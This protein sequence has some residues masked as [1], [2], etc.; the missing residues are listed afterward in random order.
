MIGLSELRQDSSLSLPEA[1][2]MIGKYCGKKPSA[3]TCSRWVIKGVRGVR[4]E[5]VR[6]GGKF[7]TTA[8][9]VHD[10]VN[11]LSNVRP[12]MTSQERQ[13][14][15]QKVHLTSPLNAKR[16]LDRVVG[17]KGGQEK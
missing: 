5:A 17:L 12:A 11:Q 13:P 8:V 9:A 14:E 10:F 6:I 7:Y 15:L 16:H 3:S 4:L 1:A 2:A